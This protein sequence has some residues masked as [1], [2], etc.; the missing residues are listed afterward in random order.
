MT[1]LRFE[2]DSVKDRANRRKHTVSF[3]E[4]KSV[5]FDDEHSEWEDRFLLLGLS[6]RLRVLIDCYCL[7]EDGKVLR[8]ISARKTTKSE[9]TYYDEGAP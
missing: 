6:F 8:I 9:R 5:F 4:A 3:E 7:R 2:W 1:D